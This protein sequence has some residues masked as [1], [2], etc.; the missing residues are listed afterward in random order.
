MRGG[1]DYSGSPFGPEAPI[2]TKY[3]KNM[4]RCPGSETHPP[5]REVRG[6]YWHLE[7]WW[8]HSG[9]EG[10]YG[11]LRKLDTRELTDRGL[12]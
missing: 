2:P 6:P 11:F 7:W 9:S 5:N 8:I 12:I 4:C 1:A 10:C 3:V